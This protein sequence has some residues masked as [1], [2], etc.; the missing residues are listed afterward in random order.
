MDRINELMDKL[1]VLGYDETYF[2][3]ILEAC[4]GKTDLATLSREELDLFENMLIKQ[5]NFALKC[6]DVTRSKK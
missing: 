4:V 5:I 1:R 3:D 6:I 2:G